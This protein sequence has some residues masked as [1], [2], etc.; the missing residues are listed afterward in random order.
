MRLATGKLYL[1]RIRVCIGSASQGEKGASRGN[2]YSK[3]GPGE[4]VIPIFRE[5]PHKNLYA[6]FSDS[7]TRILAP[8]LFGIKL[9]QVHAMQSNHGH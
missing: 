8:C 7:F 5:S 2:A 9:N 6:G 4:A 1:A 3:A